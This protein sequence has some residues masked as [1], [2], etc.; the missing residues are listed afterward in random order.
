M[1]IKKSQASIRKRQRAK[2]F[3]VFIG[4]FML[5]A[6][7]L[8]LTGYGAYSYI[9]FSPPIVTFY[10][11]QGN[12]LSEQN[13]GHGGSA[14]APDAPEKPD[15]YYATNYVFVGWSANFDNVTHRVKA[16]AVYEGDIIYYPLTI[17]TTNGGSINLSTKQVT[18]QEQINLEAY[19]DEFTTF[20]GWYNGDTLVSTSNK[21]SFKMDH[22]ELNLTAKFD[23]VNAESYTIINSATDLFNILPDGKHILG[24]DINMSTYAS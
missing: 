4:L 2:G 24:S 1:S 6:I 10:D 16:V 23:I 22:F 8:G 5:F 21:Y 12:V 13:V 20:A 19:N 11:W 14:I 17:T 9:D 7:A 3:G 18:Y 15:D